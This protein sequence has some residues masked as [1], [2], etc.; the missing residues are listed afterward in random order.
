MANLKSSKKRARQNNKRNEL[1][2][3]QRAIARTAIKKVETAINDKKKDIAVSTFKI[4]EKTIDKM[5]NKGVLHK[6]KA[7]RVKSRLIKKIQT[8]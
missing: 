3:S 6:N 2:S 5:A 4:A 8:L 1:K 7:S